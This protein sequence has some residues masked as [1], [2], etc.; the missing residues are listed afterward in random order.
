V[1]DGADMVMGMVTRRRCD[2]VGRKSCEV[3][4]RE[5]DLEA[6]KVRSKNFERI[7][8]SLAYQVQDVPTSFVAGFGER[9]E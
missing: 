1:G 8:V 9:T 3:C 2:D 4:S 7:N 6:K 5:Q